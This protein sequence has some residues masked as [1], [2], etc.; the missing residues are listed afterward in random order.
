MTG[1]RP[2]QTARA[3]AHAGLVRLKH[4]DLLTVERPPAGSKVIFV[5]LGEPFFE[6]LRDHVCASLEGEALRG[7]SDPY[8]SQPYLF[9]PA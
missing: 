7:G 5:R 4:R 6:R 3:V 8:A 2:Q 1:F 9:H